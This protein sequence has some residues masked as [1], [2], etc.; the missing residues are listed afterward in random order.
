MTILVVH[1]S[2]YGNTAKI[3]DAIAAVLPDA[4]P[5]HRITEIAAGSL[6]QALSLLVA[7]SPTQGGQPTKAMQQWVASIAPARLAGVRVSAFDTRMEPKAQ[8]FALKLLMGI[9]GFAAPRILSG[10]EARGGIAAAPAEGFV[11]E[12]REGPLRQGELE[13]AAAWARSLIETA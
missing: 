2:A 8:G 7:G 11:V 12:G 1:D 9:I 6:P 10:L 3:A 5:A 4:G 13:R